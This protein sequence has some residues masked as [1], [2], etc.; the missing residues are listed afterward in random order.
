MTNDYVSRFLG[1]PPL[2][3]VGSIHVDHVRHDRCVGS[4]TVT[5]AEGLRILGDGEA[6][7]GA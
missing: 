6:H 3:V 4:D 5:V 2:A 7:R 1:G